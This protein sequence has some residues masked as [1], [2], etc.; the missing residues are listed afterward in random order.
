MSGVWNSPLTF[1]R[2]M[3]DAG[4]GCNHE[5]EQ[6][7]LNRLPICGRIFRI[8]SRRVLGGER[9]ANRGLY[10]QP[11]QRPLGWGPKRG[12]RGLSAL[13]PAPPALPFTPRGTI[14]VFGNLT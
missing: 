4:V 12:G 10:L 5:A 1:W 6:H 11:W 13:L 3:P 2:T 9:A 8:F 7:A 14:R